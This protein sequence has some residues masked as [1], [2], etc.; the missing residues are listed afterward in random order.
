MFRKPKRSANKAGLRKK[1]RDDGDDKDNGAMGAGMMQK[2]NDDEHDGSSID[3]N[4]DQATSSGLQ[5]A[6]KRVKLSGS[7]KKQ[8]NIILKKKD[9]STKLHPNQVA[10]ME[11]LSQKEKATATNEYH[12]EDMGKPD[13]NRNKFLAQPIRAPTNVRVTCRFDYQPD[14][15]KDYKDTGFCG[16]GDTCIYLHDRGD[17]MT[18]WQLDQKW[19]Q[20]QAKKKQEK[21]RQIEAFLGE[22]DGKDDD[23][24]NAGVDDDFPFA[25]FIC[26]KAFDDPIVTPCG[27]YFCQTC[28]H[29]HNQQN[30]NQCPICKKD[31]HGVMNQPTKL[32]KNK[33]KVVGRKA[34]WQEFMDHAKQKREQPSVSEQ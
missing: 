22:G 6:R 7:S 11:A 1:P 31:T 3:D 24:D 12:P 16:F 20:E 10:P 29:Q 33:R 19:E 21:D 17:T 8:H 13:P 2:Q 5:E 30:N 28:L 34:T 15:C 26:R 9:D 14:I 23:D 4:D 18:G 32:I 27:H 25:C